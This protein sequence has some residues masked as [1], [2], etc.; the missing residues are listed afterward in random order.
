TSRSGAKESHEGGTARGFG[1]LGHI[2]RRI[3]AKY[4]D[5]TPDEEFQQV[6]VVASEL[7]DVAFGAKTEPLG[8][9]V[10]VTPCM[11]EPGIR[12]RREVGVFRENVFWSDVFLQLNEKASA[13][14]MV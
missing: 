2:C 13:A 14:D 11:I 4:R 1:G 6:S 5:P 10:D 9:H 12:I 8:Y 7:D 3:D